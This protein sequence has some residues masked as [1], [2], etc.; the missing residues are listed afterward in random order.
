MTNYEIDNKVAALK[1]SLAQAEEEQR[2]F[3]LQREREEN[4]RGFLANQIEERTVFWYDLEDLTDS[5]RT[6][7]YRG[8]KISRDKAAELR[9]KHVDR[10]LEMTGGDKELAERIVNELPV[11]WQKFD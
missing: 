5:L 2:E 10:L 1:Q 11:L 4:F 3:H 9:L 6:E 7:G 8:Y